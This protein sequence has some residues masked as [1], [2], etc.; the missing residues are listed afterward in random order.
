MFRC[1]RPPGS[2]DRFITGPSGKP[3]RKGVVRPSSRASRTR[4]REFHQPL[5]SSSFPL[6]PPSTQPFPTLTPRSSTPPSCSRGT[7]PTP[8][9]LPY[10]RSTSI[11]YFPLGWSPPNWFFFSLYSGLARTFGR[12][13]FARPTPVA[14]LRANALPALSARFASSDVGQSGKIHQVIG[15]VVDGTWFSLTRPGRDWG[16]RRNRENLFLGPNPSPNSSQSISNRP[17]GQS[18]TRYSPYYSEVRG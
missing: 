12:A 15:A 11:T 13:A 2:E 4:L 14:R 16:N 1:Y 9:G 8:F 18:L 3:P 5:S 10:R 6:F 17:H 7:S